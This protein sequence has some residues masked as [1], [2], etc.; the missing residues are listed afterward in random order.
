MT[1]ISRGLNERGTQRSFNFCEGATIKFR[2]LRAVG[3]DL[4]HGA[5]M[6][7]VRRIAR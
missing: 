5:M 7:N 2:R 3:I 6:T 1:F 4:D